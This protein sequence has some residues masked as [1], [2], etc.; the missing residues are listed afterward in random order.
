MFPAVGQHCL[1]RRWPEHQTESG[2]FSRWRSRQTASSPVARSG[3]NRKRRRWW[4]KRRRRCKIKQCSNAFFL[5]RAVTAA[6]RG[7]V[8]VPWIEAMKEYIETDDLEFGDELPDGPFADRSSGDW[9]STVMSVGSVGL[10]MLL[11]LGIV[12][13]WSLTR[14]AVQAPSTSVEPPSAKSDAADPK[15]RERG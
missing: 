4:C 8:Q 5:P 13:W 15:L 9:D 6:F 3:R 11:M 7:A 1:Q 12:L 14:P 10:A 2:F